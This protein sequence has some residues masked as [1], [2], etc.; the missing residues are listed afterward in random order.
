MAAGDIG[1]GLQGT[2][3]R[4]AGAV[5]QAQG[6]QTHLLQ[7]TDGSVNARAVCLYQVGAAID[8]PDGLAQQLADMGHHVQNAGMGAAY[9]HCQAAVNLQDHAHLV[10]EVVLPE[11]L[12]CPANKALGDL[13]KFM[14]SGE[15]R[16]QPYPRENLLQALHCMVEDVLSGQKIRAEAGGQV[17]APGSGAGEFGFKEVGAGVKGTAAQTVVCQVPEAG[18]VVVVA[19][20]DHHGVQVLQINTQAVGVALGV[21]AGAA[22][23]E[24]A[25]SVVLHIQGQAMLRD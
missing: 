6:L 12:D 23:E 4:V 3:R 7:S 18:G 5:A 14:D 21:G 22:V 15:S 17:G 11:A 20:A 25:P 8:R 10:G 24:N 9:Q 2:L 13:L 1:E 19:V 16:N